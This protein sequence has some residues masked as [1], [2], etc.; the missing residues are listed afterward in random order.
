VDW[1]NNSKIIQYDPLQNNLDINSKFENLALNFLKVDL[2]AFKNINDLYDSGLNYDYVLLK[3]YFSNYKNL[4][5]KMDEIDNIVRFLSTFIYTILDDIDEESEGLKFY[6]FYLLSR[7]L[8][9][10][11][12]HPYFGFETYGTE[13]LNKFFQ[14]YLHA[15]KKI[16]KS[17]SNLLSIFKDMPKDIFNEVVN[18]FQSHLSIYFI[19]EINH[20]EKAIAKCKYFLGVFDIFHSINVNN[21]WLKNA[22]FYNPILNNI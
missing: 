4:F 9:Y 13:G 17:N 2:S 7:N 14:I 15:Y 21:K 5:K 10:I 3:K 22:E 20:N 1:N 11:I 16:K 8:V 19:N 12:L 18:N 6:A